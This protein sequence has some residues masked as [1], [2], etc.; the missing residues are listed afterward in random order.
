MNFKQQII[1]VDLIRRSFARS[2]SGFALENADSTKLE[3]G[4]VDKGGYKWKGASEY[5]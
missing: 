3:Y 1:I 4:V 2:R 5:H